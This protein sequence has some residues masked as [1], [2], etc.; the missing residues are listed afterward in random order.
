MTAL[1]DQ[2]QEAAAFIRTKWQGTPLVGIILGTGLGKLVEDI[3]AEVTLPYQD[4]P[5]FPH[6]TAL[7]TKGNSFAERS[8]ASL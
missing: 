6:S 7:R 3:D 2:I 8:L 5:H 4:I 1:F